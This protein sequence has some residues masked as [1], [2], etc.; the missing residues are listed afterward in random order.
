MPTVL[1]RK[2]GGGGGSGGGVTSLSE[3]GQP[4]LTGAV[5][6]SEGSGVTLTQ[7]GQDIEIA[8]SGA[9]AATDGWTDD[10]ANTWTRTADQT[11]TVSGDRTA[12]FSKGTRLRWTQTTVKYGVV[13]G[14]SHAAGTTT[15]TIAITSDYVLTAAAISANSYSYAANPQGYPGWF[16]YS[17]TYTG[18]SAAPPTTT[19]KFM[20]VGNACTVH[21]D[22]GNGTSNANAFTFTLPM[23]YTVTN[24]F[25][26]ARVI[27]N[28]VPGSFLGVIFTDGGTN[29]A[30]IYRDGSA[31]AWT[32]S[33]NKAAIGL[34][35]FAF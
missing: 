30:S 1:S 16:N 4:A 23:S 21:L 7:V 18:F 33:G 35:T 31:P 34:L 19:A 14:S 12:V 22:T 15:V 8:S 26:S 17:P 9:A 3:S 6:F 32:T 5:T 25:G 29:V 28:G 10:S 13:A 11:F 20:V 24:S 27:N 2:P